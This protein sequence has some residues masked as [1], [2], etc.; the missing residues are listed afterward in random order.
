MNALPPAADTRVTAALDLQQQLQRVPN[1]EP[2]C[3]VFVRWC[4]LHGQAIGWEPDINDGVRL[5]IQPFMPAEL[6]TGERKGAGILCCRPNITW[7]KD[8]GKEPEGA[9]QQD[10][11]SWFWGCPG[12]GSGGQHT[13]FCGTPDAGFDGSRWNDLHSTNA[14]KRVAPQGS[15]PRER[16]T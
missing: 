15:H 7:R 8:R 2:P 6:R 4:P 3:D 12:D 9:S 16:M 14:V 11:F 1:G 13:D 5:N 10:D